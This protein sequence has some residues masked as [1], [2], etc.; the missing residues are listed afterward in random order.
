MKI[1]KLL[2]KTLISIAIPFIIVLIVIAPY[3]DLFYYLYDIDKPNLLDRDT[4]GFIIRRGMY[5]ATELFFAIIYIFLHL[6]WNKKYKLSYKLKKAIIPFFFALFSSPFLIYYAGPMFSFIIIAPIS[7]VLYITFLKHNLIPPY[8]A[9]NINAVLKY[10]FYGSYFNN[11]GISRL[12]FSLGLSIF[13][14]TLY[15]FSQNHRIYFGDYVIVL[16]SYFIPFIVAKVIF[17]IK[18]GFSTPPSDS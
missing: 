17:W 3:T 11:I 14:F 10:I 9:K 15:H 6:I 18:S 1:L 7:I 4:K 16:L 8:L 2:W 12:C 5:A 13:A